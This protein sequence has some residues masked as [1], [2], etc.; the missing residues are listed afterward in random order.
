MIAAPREGRR[1]ALHL[2]TAALG[3]L[4]FVL[5][6]A[7][8]GSLLLV[9]AVLAVALDAASRRFPSMRQSLEALAG[10]AF[11]PDEAGRVSGPTLLAVGYAAAWWLAPG[12]AAASAMV[13]TALADPAAAW[14][15]SRVRPLGGGKTWAGSLAV[16]ATALLLLLAF[17][18]PWPPSVGAA[19]VAMLA[20]RLPFPGADNLTLPIG[21]AVA[22][23][24]LA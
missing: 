22:L 1:R 21:T 4:A 11:R 24:W 8:T 3:A 7:L 16:L 19:A 6:G 9:L 20:E 18:H 17:G 2:A 23:R 15:G 13:V 10:G 12:R 5:P 14:V